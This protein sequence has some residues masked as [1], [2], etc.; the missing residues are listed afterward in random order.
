MRALCLN[1]NILTLALSISI[2]TGPAG[3][4]LSIIT[5]IRQAKDRRPVVKVS[6][7]SSWELSENESEC[8]FGEVLEVNI[9][10]IGT[11]PVKPRSWGLKLFD[12]NVVLTLPA[13]RELPKVMD[14]GDS[15][16]AKIEVSSII[17]AL[18]R[19]G[20]KLPD[21]DDIILTAVMTDT[22]NR[23]Y[24]A[25]DSVTLDPKTKSGKILKLGRS[26]KSSVTDA[27]FD[28]IWSRRRE[29]NLGLTDET[30]VNDP[31]AQQ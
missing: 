19:L 12:E 3:L 9:T 11:S 13:T 6:L 2:V 31:S 16:T 15:F 21:P 27:I 4:V 23:T 26:S 24:A 18:K 20:I 7:V 29:H 17:A 28:E 25:P 8:S 14:H 10:N 22:L 5:A 30:D 1:M